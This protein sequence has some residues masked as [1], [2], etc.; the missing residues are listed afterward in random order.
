M[1]TVRKIAKA[2]KITY[3][4]CLNNKSQVLQVWKSTAYCKMHIITLQQGCSL[5]APLKKGGRKACN[6]EEI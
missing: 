1:C 4:S 3:N 2:H 5:L 6:K